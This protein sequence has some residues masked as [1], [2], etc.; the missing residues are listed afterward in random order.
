MIAIPARNEA[1]RIGECLRALA[2]S[3]VQAAG[4]CRVRAIIVGANDCDD[5]TAAFAR[6]LAPSLPVPLHVVETSSPDRRA[7]AGF[8]RRRVT[9]RAARR[10]EAAGAF[11]GVVM[12]TDADSRVDEDW[13]AA[14]VAAIVAGADVVA[15]AVRYDRA[16][17]AFCP[18]SLRR[19]ER[20]ER[21]YARLLARLAAHVDPDPH[22]PW[23]RH[24]QASG[25]SLAMRL[26]WLRQVGG[27]P[28]LTSGE[29]RALVEALALAGARVR[30]ETRA[31]VTTS[32]RLVGRAKGG[33]AD[34][35]AARAVDADAPCDERLEPVGVFLNRMRRRRLLR[36]LFASR[37]TGNVSF[38]DA[39]AAE[40]GSFHAAWRGFERDSPVMRRELLAP[41]DLPR[42]IA[43]AF[44]ALR[45]LRASKG[46]R[47]AETRLDDNRP[48]AT[49]GA[50]SRNLEPAL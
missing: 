4:V 43:A 44:A 10:L 24:D 26:P 22:D 30:H 21:L 15:G 6:S 2:A 36:A 34:T 39:C 13:I 32:A 45:D 8:A 23:P 5:D 31:R 50:A 29:D 19:R 35:M 42:E 12:I 47:S 16:D 27:V 11:D 33:A 25:A 3:A 18:Q 38:A 7:Q 9:E 37:P 28:P 49:I 40:A 1:G 14:N 41:A 20:L 17:L 48:F 46:G